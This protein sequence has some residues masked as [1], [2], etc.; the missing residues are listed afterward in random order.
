VPGPGERADGLSN[1]CTL[2]MNVAF[3][4]CEGAVGMD[5]VMD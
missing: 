1:R 3:W 4:G 5:L 2:E